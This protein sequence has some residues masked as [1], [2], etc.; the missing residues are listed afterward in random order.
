MVT[1]FPRQENMFLLAARI[2]MLKLLFPCSQVGRLD[3]ASFVISSFT[4]RRS[5]SAYKQIP[6]KVCSLCSAQFSN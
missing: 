5:Y 1:S 4:S 3:L 6:E 2:A